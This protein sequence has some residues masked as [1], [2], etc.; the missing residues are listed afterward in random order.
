MASTTQLKHLINRIL[1]PAN[2]RLDTL[3]AQRQETGRLEALITKGHFQRPIFPLPDGIR[4]CDPRAVLSEVDRH[5]VRMRELAQ[6]KAGD[7]D[8][9]FN[10]NY[11]RSP[12]AEVYYAMIRRYR[13]QRIIEIGCGH[14]TRIA[15]QAIKDGGLATKMTCIDPA[16]RVDIAGYADEMIRRQ[17]EEIAPDELVKQLSANDILFI[18]SSHE[19]RTGND[20]VF[21]YLYM[22]PALQAGVLVHIHDVFLP[23]DYP[24][25][26]LREGGV[27]WN[28]QYLVQAMLSFGDRFD[29][30]WP[31][32]YLQRSHADFHMHFQ[33]LNGESRAQSFWMLKNS[34]GQHAL[35]PWH[36]QRRAEPTGK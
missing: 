24:E 9:S 3:T 36:S 25:G 20:V 11:F 26:W 4:E 32:Y 14:S 30:L 27:N 18:D 10:N 29:V 15:R 6:P 1:R 16:P 34:E 23:W 8:Y 7:F 33:N 35:A 12:D 21:L 31:G 22:L 17:V 28:E 19:I 13:P 2:L 5:A